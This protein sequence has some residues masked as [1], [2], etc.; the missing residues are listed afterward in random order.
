MLTGILT[1]CD[2]AFFEL[3]A[4][5]QYPHFLLFILPKKT[6]NFKSSSGMFFFLWKQVFKSSLDLRK[7]RIFFHKE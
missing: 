6:L 3:L 1:S 5:E 2:I 7:K 4:I